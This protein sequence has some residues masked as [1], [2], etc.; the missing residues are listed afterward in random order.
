[1]Y[2]E[3]IERISEWSRERGLD[4]EVDVAR[5]TFFSHTGPVHEEDTSFELRMAAF[6][7]FFLFDRT[8]EADEGGRTIAQ[9]YLEDNGSNLTTEERS[10]FR[11]LTR[12]HHGLFE[13]RKIA[14][15]QVVVRDLFT[16]EDHKVHERRRLA[17]LSKGDVVETRLIP[18]R[19]QLLFGRA[20]LFHPRPAKKLILKKIKKLHKSGELET[21]EDRH[22]LLGTLAR[23]ALLHD[24]QL[25]NNRS[26]PAT[27][28]IYGV[29]L[30]L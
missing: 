24:R 22:A 1:M 26:P 30:G 13:I 12:T 2:D 14:A 23:T 5:A 9:R 25:Q 15:E 29:A 28:R 20:F 8:L 16:R 21:T 17:G 27:Q 4:R 3:H 6:S 18:W 19:E 10:I 7:E 11:G